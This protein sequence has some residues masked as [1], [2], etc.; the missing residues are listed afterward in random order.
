[1]KLTI[2]INSDSLWDIHEVCQELADEF[3]KEKY[4]HEMEFKNWGENKPKIEVE[5]DEEEDE[6]DE[7]YDYPA[8]VRS[9]YISGIRGL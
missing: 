1:M 6:E 2:E 5:W 7:Y 4:P 8:Q 9:D 3:L